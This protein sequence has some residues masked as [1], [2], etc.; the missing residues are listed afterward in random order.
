M[1]A[2]DCIDGL[3]DDGHLAH[4]RQVSAVE[5]AMALRNRVPQD[6]LREMTREQ[7]VNKFSEIFAD[8][9]SR[10]REKLG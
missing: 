9:V 6:E 10:F 5:I 3:D 4:R 8:E 2:Y 7:L 1:S